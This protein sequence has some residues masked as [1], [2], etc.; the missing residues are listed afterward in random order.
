MVLR[1]EVEDNRRAIRENE[2]ECDGLRDTANNV[3]VLLRKEIDDMRRD[4]EEL[5]EILKVKNRMLDDQNVAISNLKQ[6]IRQKDDELLTL[7]EK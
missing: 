2:R 3:E 4:L 1:G 6:T 7:Q 5:E